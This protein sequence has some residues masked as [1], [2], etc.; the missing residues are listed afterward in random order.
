MYDNV[1]QV[2]DRSDHNQ[3]KVENCIYIVPIVLYVIHNFL[4]SNLS[5]P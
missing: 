5:I 3:F 4:C 1:I 2:E